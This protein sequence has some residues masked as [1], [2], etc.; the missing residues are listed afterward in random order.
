MPAYPA[1]ETGQGQSASDGPETP[2]MELGGLTKVVIHVVTSPVEVAA[3]TD[4]RHLAELEMC[5]LTT[6]GDPGL[7]EHVA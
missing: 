3:S 5:E 1:D 4:R 7:S 2:R 6:R